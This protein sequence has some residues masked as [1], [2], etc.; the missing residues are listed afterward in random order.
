LEKLPLSLEY[1]VIFFYLYFTGSV[2]LDDHLTDLSM[3]SILL[4]L[5]DWVMVVLPADTRQIVKNI[6]KHSF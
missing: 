4:A 3:A 6:S 2:C 1:F 5:T